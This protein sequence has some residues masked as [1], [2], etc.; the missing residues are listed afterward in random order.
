MPSAFSPPSFPFALWPRWKWG[1]WQRHLH[2]WGQATWL[3]DKSTNQRWVRQQARDKRGNGDGGCSLPPPSS[4][5]LSCHPPHWHPC[6][7]YPHC[8][9]RQCHW[10]HHHIVVIIP[11]GIA[12]P[13][14]PLSSLCTSWLLCVASVASLSCTALL[15]SYRAGWLFHVV[16]HLLPYCLEPPFHPL[17]AL[18]GC[19]FLRCLCCP[20]MLHSNLVL[21]CMSIL[22]MDRGVLQL[23]VEIW[24]NKPINWQQ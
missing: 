7:C 19:Y 5:P 17:A 3:D 4:P 12:P 6:H 20:I 21:S 14:C 10:R 15:S 11:G 2:C 16:P 9:W 13:A 22:S 23:T 24:T 8:R 1:R 18:A